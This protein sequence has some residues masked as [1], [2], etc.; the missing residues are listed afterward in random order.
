[1][2]RSVGRIA[3]IINRVHNEKYGEKRG[4]FGFFESI[5]DDAVAARIVRRGAAVAGR[6]RAFISCVGRSIRH[7]ITRSV[8]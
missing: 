4:F 6:I 3:G 2:A 7:S 8:C 5:D 1:M